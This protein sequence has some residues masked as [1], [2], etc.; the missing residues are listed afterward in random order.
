MLKYPQDMNHHKDIRISESVESH[1]VDNQTMYISIPRWNLW[2]E[3]KKHQI[4]P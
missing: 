3:L 2:L 4:A 1:Y